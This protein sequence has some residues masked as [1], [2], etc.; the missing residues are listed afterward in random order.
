MGGMM[1]R[2]S[3]MDFLPRGEPS[4]QPSFV[5]MSYLKHEGPGGPAVHV[6]KKRGRP[7]KE[8]KGLKG[9]DKGEG[10]QRKKLKIMT[11]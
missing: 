11:T 3:G 6:P 7:V 4:G 10:K 8:D 1:G 9:D 5:D 2:G